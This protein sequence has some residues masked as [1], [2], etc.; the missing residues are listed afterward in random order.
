MN[1]KVSFGNC[2]VDDELIRLTELCSESKLNL[3]LAKCNII[4]W[5]INKDSYCKK[6]KLYESMIGCCENKIIN[7]GMCK[8]Q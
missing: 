2:S 8:V 4:L 1:N 7:Y 5:L 6:I 3:L